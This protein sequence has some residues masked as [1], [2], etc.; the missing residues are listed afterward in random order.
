MIL[1]TGANGH[2]GNATINFLLEKGVQGNQISALVRKEESAVEFRNRGVNAVIGDYD[3]Y[4]SLLNAFKGVDKLL[5]VSGSDLLNRLSQH[6]NVINAA[7]EARVK[8]IVYTSISAK[9]ETETSPLWL[10]V[11]SHLQTEQWLKESGVDFTILKNNLYMDLI[12]AFVGE[13]VL[14]TGLIYLPTEDGKV[15][16]V[17]R[18]ELA[19][20]TAKVLIGVDHEGKV[21]DFSN[22]EAFS[23]Q[24]VAKVISDITGKS[25]NYVS[26]SAEEY[27]DTLS[28]YGVPQDFI[29][30]FSSFAV[31]QAQGELDTTNDDLEKI[32]NRKPTSIKEF[33]SQVYTQATPI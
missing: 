7:K 15:G 29:E 10:V 17:L 3:S 23:Y 1:V 26:P 11:K 30:L 21:Y 12:P 27:A 18:S 9:N 20:A 4:D 25:I 6:Q 19:E 13:K 28:K 31:A 32:L 22:P 33:L 14:E 16:A 5:F 8:H 2:F 24:E